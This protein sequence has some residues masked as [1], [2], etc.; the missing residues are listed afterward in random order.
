MS[1]AVVMLILLQHA[2]CRE[3]GAQAVTG[4]TCSHTGGRPWHQ[5]GQVA[6]GWAT[7][8]SM[9]ISKSA[10]LLYIL[11]GPALSLQREQAGAAAA[12]QQDGPKSTELHKR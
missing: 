2:A 6:V 3:Q 5:Y 8:S 1:F 9:R 10:E 7:L 12:K 4:A 11:R